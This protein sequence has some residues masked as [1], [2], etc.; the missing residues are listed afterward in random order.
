MI[1]YF[2]CLFVIVVEACESSRQYFDFMVGLCN[3]D[4]EK[5]YVNGIR[6]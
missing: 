1:D 2:Y 6:G 3:V 4:I 5:V